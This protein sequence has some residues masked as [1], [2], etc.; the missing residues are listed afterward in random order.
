[1]RQLTI[2][3]MAFFLIGCNAGG[4]FAAGQ[5]MQGFGA[6]LQANEAANAP[7]AAYNEAMHAYNEQLAKRLDLETKLNQQRAS[8]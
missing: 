2:I 5:L 1:M 3:A 6:H 7:L 4:M 8:C